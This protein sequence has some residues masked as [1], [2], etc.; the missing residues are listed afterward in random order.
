MTAPVTGW[1]L[2][3]NLLVNGDFSDGTTGWKFPSACF[4]IDP[5]TPAPNGAASIELSNPATCT[6]NALAA[7]NSL[8]VSGGEIYTLSGQ[9]KTENIAGANSTPGVMFD[10]FDYCDSPVTKGTTDWTTTTLQHVPVQSG[11]A[12]VVKLQTYDKV[13]TGNAWFANISLQQEIPP[14]L[15]VFLLYPNYRGLMFSDQSQV[16]S[17]DLVVTPPAGTSLS[18]L[19]VVIN[20]LDAGGDTVASQTFTPK[21]A[22]FTAALDMTSLPPGTY[23]VAGT[24]EDSRGNV[25]IAQS[26]YAIVKLDASLRSGMKAWI[27]P[28]N[29][30]HFIDGNPH[31]VLGIYDTTGYSTNPAYY[32]E[33]LAAIAEAPVNMII[34]YAITNARTQAITAYTTAMKQFGITFLPDVQPFYTGAGNFP[35]NVANEFGTYDQDQL[36]SDYASTL[37]SDP[38]VVGYYVQDEPPISA[39]PKTFHQYGLIKAN[40]P[41]GFN[42]AM[43]DDPHLPFWKDTVDVLGVDPYPIAHASGNDLAEVAYSTRAAFQAGH[44]SRP[45][46]T[47]IQFFQMNMESAWPTQQQLHDM[48][49]MAIVEGATGLFYWSYGARTRVGEGSGRARGALPGIDQRDLRDQ[50]P[51]AGVAQPRRPGDH[52]Q[53]RRRLRVH[54]D[55]GRG[56]RNP[57]P[58]LVQLHRVGCHPRVHACATRGQHYRLRHRSQHCARHQYDFFRDIP[59]L[60]GARPS[61]Q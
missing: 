50:I 2:S 39:Q 19:R 37:S 27:D 25:L 60:P 43:V 51:G 6:K 14:P 9:L 5:A 13:L 8:I 38:G 1:T 56:R 4:A 28:A 24:L 30:A 31:F 11:G 40:D 18:S 3:S 12:T 57:L 53:L 23:Q 46:W 44:G 41:S 20:A 54:Q 33:R 61:H 21:S 10:L 7:V 47:V 59:A 45:V 17:M 58:V 48:S 32:A 42:L 52:C 35:T 22:E 29:L 55:Q 26:P 49:W 15:Q 36:I 34:N 16:A